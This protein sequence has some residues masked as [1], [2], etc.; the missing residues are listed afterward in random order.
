[1]PQ[2]NKDIFDA[3]LERRQ[4]A[5][6]AALDKSES[7]TAVA[8][9][10]EPKPEPV[11]EP[12]PIKAGKAM[13]PAETATNLVKVRHAETALTQ[14]EI[15][16]KECGLASIGK[17]PAFLRTFKMA[18][19]IRLLNELITDAMLDD[20]MALQG[21]SLGFRTDKDKNGG[22]AKPIVK[23]CLIEATLRGAYCVGNE[24]NII[25]SRAYLTKEFFERVVGQLEGL[26]DLNVRLG[27][28]VMANSG[29]GAV[30]PVLASWKLNG[31]PMEL[32][33]TLQK[34]S[35]TVSIDERIPVRV[36]EGQGA[37]AIHGKAKRK[38]FARIYARCTGSDLDDVDEGTTIDARS[39]A[40]RSLDDL[41]AK[42]E[43]ETAVPQGST[44]EDSDGSAK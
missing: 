39:T 14:I 20:I 23:Q 37:D 38:A 17:M 42:L 24:W 32:N 25:A 18:A 15:I 3:E 2:A 8:E 7:A 5:A 41:S 33:C 27:V 43:G 9:K 13:M 36:N 16:A 26:T 44:G 10:P 40:V 4:K 11:P 35:E 29:G 28:P 22:Y 21:T 19:G 31:R 34:I 6:Q 30:V 1:M 12:T